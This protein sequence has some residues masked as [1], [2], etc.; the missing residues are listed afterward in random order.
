MK[1][2]F[3]ALAAISL[4]SAA[5]SARQTRNLSKARPISEEQL[6]ELNNAVSYNNPYYNS[7]YSG[8]KY[9]SD[10]TTTAWGVYMDFQ[11]SGYYS[12]NANYFDQEE[13][14]STGYSAAFS[15]VYNVYQQAN[16]GQN[17]NNN[18]NTNVEY[19]FTL[20]KDH[21]IQFKECVSL[22]TYDE[23]LFYENLL[24]YTKTGQLVAQKS[25]VL[26]DVCKTGSCS[27]RTSEHHTFMI[28]LEDW[29]GSS[30]D[31]QFEQDEE[32]CEMCL[33]SQDFCE[34]YYPQIFQQSAANDN[35]DDQGQVDGQ[36]QEANGQD[37]D[38]GDAEAQADDA[39]AERRRLKRVAVN[40]QQCASK[41]CFDLDNDGQ[42][43]N[44]EEMQSWEDAA[45]WVDDLLGCMQTDA[46]FEGYQLY[47][48]FM[49]NGKGTGAEIAMF[50]DDACSIYVPSV[51]FQEYINGQYYGGYAYQGGQVDGQ[52]EAQQQGQGQNGQNGQ[53]G[54]YQ[55]YGG[56]NE[57]YYNYEMNGNQVDLSEAHDIVTYTFN[58]RIDCRSVDYVAA[59]YDFSAEWKQYK[60]QQEGE[61]EQ[62]GDMNDMT[63]QEKMQYYE[64]QAQYYKQQD[65]SAVRY[66]QEEP[67][68]FCQ[69]IFQDNARDVDKCTARA[70]QYGYYVGQ[71]E[72][73]WQY[74]GFV[75]E[76]DLTEDDAESSWRTCIAV[77][78]LEGQYSNSRIYDHE[79]SGTTF[80]YK[81]NFESQGFLDRFTDEDAKRVGLIAFL[82][83]LGAAL[84]YGIVLTIRNACSKSEDENEKAFALLDEPEMEKPSVSLT[85]AAY[86]EKESLDGTM[87]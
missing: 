14:Q 53:N 40:C 21:S 46:Y 87:A 5:G 29:V 64:E 24:P 18:V 2:L 33:E 9:G 34:T 72:G 19:F 78:R 75:Y 44:Y 74:G 84:M 65:N 80:E 15:S 36:E 73:E 69:R 83:I 49:C 51:S 70:K 50:L 43:D 41:E 59:D 45:E 48:G 22:R 8:Y 60:Y 17:A 66:Y 71:E 79:S 81:K 86:G 6:R 7:Q 62:A 63:Y 4:N 3:L 28:E 76:Y 16:N 13:R 42:A 61:D 39:G 32:Y 82:S 30:I 77:A 67:T 10:E 20:S 55:Q 1:F 37:A 52:E 27:Q 35:M 68:E 38:A 23:T 31:M 54:Q 57:Q 58:N 12:E 11:N 25:V 47:A 26:F 56:V 85:A